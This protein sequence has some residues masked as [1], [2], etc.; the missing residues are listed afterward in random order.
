MRVAHRLVELLR[1]RAAI[2]HHYG[3]RSIA[4]ADHKQDHQEQDIDGHQYADNGKRALGER[5]LD[6]LLHAGPDNPQVVEGQGG[7]LREAASLS[8]W[9]F[10]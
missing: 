7:W 3:G 8:R 10:L 6:I 1:I 9:R 2:V 4:A 5:D